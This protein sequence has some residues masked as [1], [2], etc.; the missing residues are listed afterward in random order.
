VD[1]SVVAADAMVCW[2]SFESSS[3]AGAWGPGD[4]QRFGGLHCLPGLLRHH[5]N[6]IFAGDNLD[7][8]GHIFD[9]TFVHA[10]Q[11]RADG[12]WSHYAPV[13]H[14]WQA[15]VVDILEIPRSH[16]RHVGTGDGLA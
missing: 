7:H 1:L 13:Q 16:E 14:S 11:R 8:P 15:H 4:L 6:E 5:A 2:V 10:D 3:F 9:R 12:R